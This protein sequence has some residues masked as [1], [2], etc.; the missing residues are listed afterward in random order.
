M[1]RT[2]S[3]LVD[4]PI[5]KTSADKEVDADEDFDAP[6][7]VSLSDDAEKDIKKMVA[8]RK[9]EIYWEKKRLKDQ[10]DDFEESEFDF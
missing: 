9:I 5:E 6:E 4:K 8:R 10:F 7:Y 2:P 3:K 1:A